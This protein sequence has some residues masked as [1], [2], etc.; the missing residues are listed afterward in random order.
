VA[1][2]GDKGKSGSNN[3]ADFGKPWNS[4]DRVKVFFGGE[5]KNSSGGNKFLM[6]EIIIVDLVAMDFVMDFM[7]GDFVID[8]VMDLAKVNFVVVD[9]MTGD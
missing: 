7:K 1:V 5:N 9:L 4:G 8:V 6:M 2:N 3:S